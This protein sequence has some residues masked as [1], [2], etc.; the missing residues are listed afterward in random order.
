VTGARS[1]RPAGVRAEER[2]RLDAV[3]DAAAAATSL[4]EFLRTTLAALDEYLGYAHS[5]LMLVLAQQRGNRAY[6]GVNHGYR[7]YVMAEYFERWAACDALTSAAAAESFRGTGSATV[8]GIHHRL[9][10]AGRRYVDDFLKRHHAGGLLSRRVPVGRTDAYL[11]V[12]GRDESPERD[13][14]VL[15]T[16]APE[17]A[18]L[19]RG[20]LPRGFSGAFTLRETQTA[21]LVALGFSNREIA[22]VFQVEED[23]VKKYVSRAMARIGV[24]RRTALAVAWAT[25][26]RMDVNGAR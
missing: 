24:E 23:T 1:V 25:G 12:F 4:D 18:A 6:A 16:L 22:D 8:A 14:R 9:D 13:D 26:R 19:L 2:R 3:L 17:L 20:Y 11:T 15:R 7:E 10:A 21:E 5:A